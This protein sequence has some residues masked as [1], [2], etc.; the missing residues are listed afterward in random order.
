MI[1]RSSTASSASTPSI[2][3]AKYICRRSQ[4]SQN[5]QGKYD[6]CHRQAG[7]S[8]LTNSLP[9]STRH[10][11]SNRSLSSSTLF[12]E[13]PMPEIP[14]SKLFW[15]HKCC[16]SC[17]SYII[18]PGANL[19]P[20]PSFPMA[21]A[22]SSYRLEPELLR[23]SLRATFWKHCSLPKQHPVFRAPCVFS[24]HVLFVGQRRAT[25]AVG[26]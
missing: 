6:L 3:N 14:L 8:L 9:S 4:S 5:F 12:S 24:C 11:S 20:V 26:R 18:A 2:S 19:L 16:P 21:K 13:E 15:Q 17:S 25:P 10:S 23:R 7:L 22:S 1:L